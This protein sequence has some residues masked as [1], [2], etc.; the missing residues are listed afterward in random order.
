MSEAVVF[1]MDGLMIDS[2]PYWQAAQLEILQPLGVPITLQDTIDTTGMRIDQIV[3]KCYA[4]TPWNSASCSEVCDRI[5]QRVTELVCEHKPV[6][7][8]LAHAIRVCQ[9]Q[10]VK[11]GLASSS[12]MSL[13]DATLEML[14]MKDVFLVKTSAEHLRYGKPHPEVYLNACDALNVQPYHC[15]AIEDSF[16]GLLAAKAALMKTIVVPERSAADDKQFVI[17][18]HQLASLEELTP[19]LF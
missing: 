8:G 4:E 13:I 9:Q 11:L 7:P 15:V 18:D 12:P 14:Q 5:L 2:Q 10:G 17:A 19:E 6:M 1:D 3:D 16:V